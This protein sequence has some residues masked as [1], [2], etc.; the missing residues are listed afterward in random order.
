MAATAL[1]LAPR[2]S[3]AAGGVTTLFLHDG[4]RVLLEKQGSTY[5]AVYA[6]GNAL[7]RKDG[8][9]PLFD[10]LGSERTVTNASQAVTGTI[11]F[12]AFGQTVGSTGSSGNSYMF[13][14]TSGYRADGDAGLSHVGA[15]YYDAQVG[16]FITRDTQLDQHPYLYCNHDPVNQLDP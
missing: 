9:Y 14:A 10:G 7:V 3:R 11:N 4:G 2:Y 12:E 5:T 16:R 15:R 8:E 1:P 13:G 6:Y